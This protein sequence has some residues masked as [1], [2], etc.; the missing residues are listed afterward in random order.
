MAL[1]NIEYDAV[2]RRYDEV[3]EKNRLL[4]M[5][6]TQEIYREIPEMMSLDDEIAA[7]SLDAAHR[8]IENRDADLSEYSSHMKRIQSLKCS[9]LTGHGYPETYLDLQY[10]CP[11]CHDTGLI[12]GKHCRCFDKIT[13]E[14]IYG[15]YSLREILDKENFG[16]FSFDWYSDKIID[17][18]TGKSALETAREAVQTVRGMFD[19]TKIRGS[20][21][22]YGN[23]GVGKT[24]LTH[25][26]AKEAIDLGLLVLCFSAGDFFDSLAEA[27]FDK[28]AG[29]GRALKELAK[30][31][32][33][34]VIDDLG[35]ELTNAFTSS[36]LFRVINER[37]VSGKSTVISTNLNLRELSEKYS[38]RVLS[39][40]TSDYII[41]KLIGDDIRIQ[42]KLGRRQA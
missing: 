34:L 15:R 23:T 36:E 42:K 10:D 20:L 29:R 39:R 16:H 14:L 28:N 18:I 11:D 35:T 4:Q 7:R 27:A 26:I 1:S 33:L 8:R 12:D 9:L 2:M 38:E 3:R 21:Y 25:C 6:R 32:D 13:A 37:H 24:F 30:S 40:I 41:L 5:Q 19:G 17:E 22:L 31:A